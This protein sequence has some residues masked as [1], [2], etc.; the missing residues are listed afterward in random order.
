MHIMG[1]KE[2]SASNGRT[3]WMTIIS[4]VPEENCLIGN[5]SHNTL[6][7]Q[8]DHRLKLDFL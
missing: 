2:K 4:L 8:F 1:L 5:I 3:G 6:N 7:I